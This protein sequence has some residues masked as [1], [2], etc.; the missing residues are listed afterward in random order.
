MMRRSS[1]ALAS[2]VGLASLLSLT[3]AGCGKSRSARAAEGSPEAE[4]GTTPVV[5][6][7]PNEAS[8]TGASLAKEPALGP[9]E[10]IHFIGR[11][12]TTDPAGPRF[13]WSGSS[14]MARFSGTSIVAN[15]RD[16][17]DNFFNVQIDDGAPTVLAMRRGVTRYPLA[18]GL[19]PGEHRVLLFKRTEG[20][21]STVQFL[22]F[23]VPGGALVPTAWP[24]KRRIEIIGDS[25]SA[26]YGN[27][28]RSPCPFTG[29]TENAWEAYGFV[30]GRALD[31]EVT[32]V[33]WSGHGVVR[34][35]DGSTSAL[36]P[37]LYEQT[38]GRTAGSWTFGAE[39]DVVVV[40][41]GTNDWARGDPGPGFT[42]GFVTFATK[43]RQRYPSSFLFIAQGS[44]MGDR[45]SRAAL[46]SVVAARRAQ[47]DARVAFLEFPVQQA[48]DGYGC[49]GHPSLRTHGKMAEVLS[50]AIRRQLGW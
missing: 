1:V 48:A 49:D 2:L 12:D 8:L 43:I 32:A 46:T 6:P 35:Y 30:A 25:I 14:L 26:G 31:A 44:M 4:G 17:G 34:N 15:L 50:S 19:P 11:F 47:G 22:G 33:A 23:D 36:V 41:L 7:P 13:S 10:A 9:T 5:D 16:E 24:R 28:G 21:F 39:P 40:N 3:N 27:E 29:A 37:Y 42:A 45:A 18:E 20:M 38:L